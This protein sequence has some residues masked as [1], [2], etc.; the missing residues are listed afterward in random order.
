MRESLFLKVSVLT[1]AAGSFLLAG[2]V[3]RDRDVHYRERSPVVVED[4]V[5]VGVGAG[6]TV[7]S[8]PPPPIAEQ[9][10]V[11]PGPDYL[12]IPGV[13]VWNGRWNW[14]RGHWDHRPHPGAVWVPHRYV[15][16]N[17]AHVFV[18]GGWR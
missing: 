18:R 5:G 13:Y 3:V 11:S 9:I 15:Y 12:W 6:V 14:E 4:P 2:C 1:A 8:A 10:T 7:D 16:R 17:G